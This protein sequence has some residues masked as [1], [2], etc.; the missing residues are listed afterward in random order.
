[1]TVHLPH[2]R[3]ERL[4]EI[5]ASILINQ[6]RIS[7][8]KWYKVLGELCSMALALPGACHFFSHMQLALFKNIK[9]C[10]NLTKGVH[11]AL[12]DFR[13]IL[14][15]IKL[16]PTRIAKLIPLLASAKCHHNASGAGSGGGVPAKQLNPRVGYRN[17]PVLW[18]LKGPQYIIDE[19]VTTKKSTGTIFNSNLD[20]NTLFWQRKSSATTAKV[21]AHL[22]QQ[23]GIHQ[24][25][26]R[27][28]P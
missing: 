7:I 21:P 1:M 28:V 16:C 9:N 5:L 6:K 15:D 10:V 3:A 8:R 26:H 25:F 11:D 13:W 2:H 4:A 19:L 20:L 12:E 27:Y 22:L 14:R 24:W 23:F 17:G 18:R